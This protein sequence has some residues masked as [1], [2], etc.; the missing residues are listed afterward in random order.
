MSIDPLCY[1]ITDHVAQ[2]GIGSLVLRW[3]R[4]DGESAPRDGG[5]NYRARAY[6][7]WAHG[8]WVGGPP[9]RSSNALARAVEERGVAAVAAELR[10]LHAVLMLEA[11]G[12]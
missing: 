9:S 2:G 12:A 11:F 7:R 8:S 4:A 3:L 5:P 6:M 10:A 1:A